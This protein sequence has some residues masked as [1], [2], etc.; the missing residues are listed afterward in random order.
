MY[1]YYGHYGSNTQP[2]IRQ[3]STG[4]AVSLLR[5]ALYATGSHPAVNLNDTTFDADLKL[6]VEFYQ[7]NNGLGVD[8]IVGPRTWASLGYTGASCG[9]SR[10][11]SGGSSGSSST[12]LATST[13]ITQRKWFLPTVG[14]IVGVAILGL[15]FWPKKKKGK[16]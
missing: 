10:S 11:S 1:G 3:G 2:C 8:G 4:A 14:G 6:E 13:P 15:L 5:T 16:K 12:A 9:S 7:E